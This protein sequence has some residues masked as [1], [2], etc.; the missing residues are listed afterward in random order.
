QPR[1]RRRT[2]PWRIPAHDGRDRR[3]AQRVQSIKDRAGPLLPDLAPAGPAR[4]SAELR[5]EDFSGGGTER[6]I[7][8][9]GLAGWPQRMFDNSSG[10][11]CIPVVLG[12]RTGGRAFDA[13]RPLRMAT[14]SARDGAT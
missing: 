14:G 4:S 9:G 5:A 12:P 6:E 10:C 8:I 1:S 2:S 7:A 13:L 11:R 3:A